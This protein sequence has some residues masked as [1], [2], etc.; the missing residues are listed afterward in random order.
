MFDPSLFYHQ[1]GKPAIGVSACLAGQAVR[2]DGTDKHLPAVS[3][4]L[5]RFADIK[6]VC[7][8]A[9]AGFGTPRPPIQRMMINNHYS[10]NL[11]ESHEDVST[12]LQRFADAMARQYRHRLQAFIVKARSPSCGLG[13]TPVFDANGRV[14]DYNNG[15]FTDSLQKAWPWCVFVDE[16]FLTDELDCRELLLRC[17][18]C[19]DWQ[20]AATVAAQNHLLRHYNTLAGTHWSVNQWQQSLQDPA[21]RFLQ[22]LLPQA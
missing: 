16:S 1:L 18:L 17:Y 9:G 22:Y 11:V 13:T 20:K 3:G 4:F 15:V 19:A 14:I 2:Y 21:V 5:A 10:V 12:P 6:P 7:P 8:E